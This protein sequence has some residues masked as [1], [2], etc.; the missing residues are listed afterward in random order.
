MLLSPLV[1]YVIIISYF[2]LQFILTL[3]DGLAHTRRDKIHV[4]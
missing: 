3:D 4:F 2:P 1:M